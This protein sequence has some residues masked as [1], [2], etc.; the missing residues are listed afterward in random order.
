MLANRYDGIDLP[1]DACRIL[2]FDEKPYS[3]SLIDMHQEHCRQSSEATIMRTVRTIEQGMGRSVRGEKDYSVIIVLG[4]DLVRLLREKISKKYLSPQIAKQIE[5]GLEIANFAR[6]D[7]EDGNLPSRVLYELVK[8]CLNRDPDWKAYYS[9]QMD[10]VVP[11]KSN[12]KVLDMYTAELNAEKKFL[13]GDYATAC[14]RLQDIIDHKLIDSGD[15]G[16]Y[17]QEKARYLYVADRPESQKLQVAAHKNNRYLLKPPTGVTV[18]KLILVSHGR[19]ERIAKWARNFDTYAELNICVTDILD[20]LVF[21]TKAEKFESALDELSRTIGFVGERPDSEWKEGP[22]NLWA[23]DD[24]HYVIFECKSEVLLERAEINKR[25]AEQMNRSSSW[26]E[27]HYPGKRSK[28]VIVHPAGKIESAAAFTHN[29]VGMRERD[30]KAFVKAVSSFFKS[31]ES[32]DFHDLSPNRIQEMIDDYKISV[33]D[34]FTGYSS[35]L[36]DLK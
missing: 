31:F 8:Q 30:L 14:K 24:T 4:A 16:W 10:Q 29:V 34:I 22:D 6:Q 18:A 15:K 1:D 32:V 9:E 5:I 33:N 20:R 23:L 19:A 7:V 3:E 13:E 36:R 2:I 17:I 21:G 26:F 28:R 27:K 12:K 25:E 35:K 11:L